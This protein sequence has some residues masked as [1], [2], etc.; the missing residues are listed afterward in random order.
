MA[1]GLS[2][3]RLAIIGAHGGAASVHL[4]KVSDGLFCY[5]I[6]E[7]GIEPTE[8]EPLLL[9][10]AAVFEGVVC[11]LYVVT[12]VVEDADAMLFGK[13]FKGCLASIVSLEVSLVI[14]WMYFSLK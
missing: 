5:A 9:C 3:W 1:K 7:K 4:S 12:M 6:L 13:G 10:T 11:K 2:G 14:R 8:G